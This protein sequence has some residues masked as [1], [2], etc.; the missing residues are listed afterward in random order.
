LKLGYKERGEKKMKLHH[1][2]PLTEQRWEKELCL[3]EK[4]V[5]VNWRR[6]LELELELEERI[7]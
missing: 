6:E 3:S 5:S 1:C 4:V 2:K 7:S